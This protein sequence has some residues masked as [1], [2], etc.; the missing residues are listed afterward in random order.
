MT[1]MLNTRPSPPK[2]YGRALCMTCV[3]NSRPFL[4][5]D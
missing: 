2:G 3:H 4:L 1:C 5:K